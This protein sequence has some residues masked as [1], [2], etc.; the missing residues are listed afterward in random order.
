MYYGYQS[1]RRT[2]NGKNGSV[3]VPSDKADVVKTA[4]Q[5][6]Q[7][8]ATSLSDILFYFRNNGIEL[9]DTEK[10][11]MDRSHLSQILKSPLYVRADMNVYQLFGIKRL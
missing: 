8:P 7:N 10:N 5:M 1:E 6:Y 4:Y 11:N 2:V 3:L 9:N